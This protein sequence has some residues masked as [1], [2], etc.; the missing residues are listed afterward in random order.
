[1]DEFEKMGFTVQR[2]LVGKHPAFG[3]DIDMPTA[4]KA[5][6]KG[7]EGG[8]TIGLMLEYDAL[9]NGHA[10]GHN[11][12]ASAGFAA[13]IGLQELFKTIPGDLVVYGTPAEELDGSKHYI[14]AGGFME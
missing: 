2:G 13:A 14:L 11:L 5:V 7:K 4:F 6:F 10:C 12:I 9:P 8:P 3:Y 1:M